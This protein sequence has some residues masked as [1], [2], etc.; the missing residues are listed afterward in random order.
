[1]ANPQAAA[2]D[3]A[4]ATEEVCLTELPDISL[5]RTGRDAICAERMPGSAELAD[6]I[7]RLTSKFEQQTPETIALALFAAYVARTNENREA[8]FVVTEPSPGQ[9]AA[10]GVLCIGVG[11]ED[12]FGAVVLACATHRMRSHLPV[13]PRWR[14][15][16][17]HE[18]PPLVFSIGPEPVTAACEIQMHVDDRAR[19]SWAYRSNVAP[20]AVKRIEERLV[21][22]AGSILCAPET[23]VSRLEILSSGEREMILH[24]FNNTE[25][26]YPYDGG[27]VEVYI[28]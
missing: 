3:L 23:P 6:K 21:A 16:A 13:T 22:M 17:A 10:C 7:N 27:L 25:V 8:A 2:A 11:P 14:G 20:E 9:I 5:Y 1:M 15:D 4:M 26:D 24:A 12:D 19:V 28:V 18:V